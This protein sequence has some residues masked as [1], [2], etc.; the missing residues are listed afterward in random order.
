MILQ[1]F[2][3]GRIVVDDGDPAFGEDR[4]RPNARKLE[5]ARRVDRA[6]GKQDLRVSESVVH[7]A[8]L[9]VADAAGSC[10]FEQDLLCWRVRQ[11]TQVG[12]LHRR[13][14][15]ALGGTPAPTV[16]LVDVEE[17]RA[18]VVALIEIVARHDA[19]LCCA[20]LH[21]AE[22]VPC[23]PLA[24]DL[25]LAARAVERRVSAVMVLRL[26]EIGQHV[27]PPPSDISQLPPAVVV[28]CLSA[29]VNHAVHRRAAAQQLSERIGQRSSVQAGLSC[30]LHPPVGARIPDAVE[31]ADRDVDPVILVG[32][33]CLEQQDPYPGVLRQAV[34]QHASGRASSHDDVVVSFFRRSGLGSHNAPCF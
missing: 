27:V 14:K 13:S 29:H 10:A 33:A 18:L 1:I 19:Q 24:R 3:D 34:R 15:E 7:L 22:N 11:D 32:P 17:A 20:L 2:A 26:D 5:N 28:T 30:G 23:Q 6:G 16:A 12:T 25:P 31:I 9:A 4:R 21:C 8:A